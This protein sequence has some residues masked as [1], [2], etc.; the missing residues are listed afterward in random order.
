M[1]CPNLDEKMKIGSEGMTPTYHKKDHI[2]G[3]EDVTQQ[4]DTTSMEV[5]LV[6]LF[7]ASAR[8]MVVKIV[9]SSS[10]V[11][12]HTIK[13]TMIYPSSGLS[14]EVIALHPVA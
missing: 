14:L 9:R 10:E 1:R 4:D 12:I 13:H 7:F 2:S 11:V 3:M 6:S 5:V 8:Y